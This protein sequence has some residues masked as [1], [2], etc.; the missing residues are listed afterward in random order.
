MVNLKSIETQVLWFIKGLPI[1]HTYQLTTGI[2][3]LRIN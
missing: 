1:N 3:S 2:N